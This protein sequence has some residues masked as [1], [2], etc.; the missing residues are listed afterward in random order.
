[1]KIAG[2]AYTVII[3]FNR[4]AIKENAGN[5]MENRY[6]ADRTGYREKPT[7]SAHHRL[8][9]ISY[10]ESA[11]QKTTIGTLLPVKKKKKA[12]AGRK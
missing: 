10:P 1:M 3:N 5:N 12:I 9:E 2:P 7:T 8:D 4:I 6:F 11:A